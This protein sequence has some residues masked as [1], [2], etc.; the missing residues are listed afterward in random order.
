MYITFENEFGSIRITGGGDGSWR[1]IA[2]EGLDPV[3]YDVQA[4]YMSGREGRAV[5]ALQSLERTITLKG[6]IAVK[7]SEQVLARVSRILSCEGKLKIVKNTKQRMITARCTAFVTERE[8]GGIRPFVMQFVCDDPFFT[9]LTAKERDIST[10]EKLL[11]GSFTLSDGIYLSI[12]YA[13]AI[14][15]NSG[16]KAA[17]PVITIGCHKDIQGSVITIT[18]RTTG[19]ELRL[20]LA[21]KAGESLVVDIPQRRILADNIQRFD[22]LSEDS[23]LSEFHLL[24]GNNQLT[25]ATD[26]NSD[27]L[28]ARVSYYNRY[29]EA[30]I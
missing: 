11:Y 20:N 9:D 6:D 17:E 16:V 15:T 10:V 8:Q 19:Q 25:I 12:G 4:A 28:T 24:P 26:H 7:N 30:M 29:N 18:N 14:L 5:S 13:D 2:A 22:I 3:Q 27:R 23:F 21:L 1:L